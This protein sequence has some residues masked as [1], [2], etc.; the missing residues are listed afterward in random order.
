VEAGKESFEE[1]KQQAESTKIEE[2][3]CF[4]ESVQHEEST[5]QLVT[6]FKSMVVTDTRMQ[7]NSVTWTRVPST[8]FPT[9]GM[10]Q[11][12]ALTKTRPTSFARRLCVWFLS[13]GLVYLRALVSVMRLLLKIWS[14]L[15]EFGVRIGSVGMMKLEI[16]LVLDVPLIDVGERVVN[17]VKNGRVDLA[18]GARRLIPVNI[19]GSGVVMR[20]KKCF[21]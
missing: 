9:R 21:L 20:V 4:E 12:H 6:S 7:V 13:G 16:G 17:W 18:A 10:Y 3:A 19:P 14:R 1:S 11:V 2:V 8:Y 5:K 15:M